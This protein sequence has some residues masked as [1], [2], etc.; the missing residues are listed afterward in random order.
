MSWFYRFF[1][2]S[3]NEQVVTLTAPAIQLTGTATLT[4]ALAQTGDL[5]VTGAVKGTTLTSTGTARIVT[6]P[7]YLGT[8]TQ[9]IGFG[10]IGID[11]IT[12]GLTGYDK[13]SVFVGGT[14]GFYYKTDYASTSWASIDAYD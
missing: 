2:K 1:Q 10:T 7:I 6:S 8:G 12:N 4:G 3:D 5:T 11:P 14:A 9:A 13:G